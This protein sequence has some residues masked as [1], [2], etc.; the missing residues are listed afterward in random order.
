MPIGGSDRASLAWQLDPDDPTQ[1]TDRVAGRLILGIAGRES[2]TNVVGQRLAVARD[3]ELLDHQR[4]GIGD[5]AVGQDPREARG[6]ERLLASMQILEVGDGVER[7]PFSAIRR[8][9]R[10][11][12][13]ATDA[14]T[15][16]RDTSGDRGR[17]SLTDLDRTRHSVTHGST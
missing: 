14:C 16:G 9:S 1:I 7:P 17:A 3:A 8:I 11:S 13:R 2:R 12:S 6:R 4:L 10:S 15:V 5:A